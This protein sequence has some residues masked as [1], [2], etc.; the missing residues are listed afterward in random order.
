[1]VVVRESCRW[2][3]GRG[4]SLNLDD[5][6]EACGGSGRVPVHHAPTP[7]DLLADPQV[8]ALLEAART[9]AVTDEDWVYADMG[10]LRRALAPFEEVPRG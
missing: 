7:A 2:C 10:R 9:A 6:C 3:G 8:R 1:M 5:E 4:E